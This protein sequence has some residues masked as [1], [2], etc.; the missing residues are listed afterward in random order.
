[1]PPTFL[2]SAVNKLG[3][4]EILNFIEETINNLSN[5]V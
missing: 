4:E 3:R 5:V 2:S 1:M